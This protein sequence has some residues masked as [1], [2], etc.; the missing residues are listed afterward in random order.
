MDSTT[1]L[2][3]VVSSSFTSSN[4]SQKSFTD[5][6][7]IFLAVVATR[8]KIRTDEVLRNPMSKGLFAE[9]QLGKHMC[10]VMGRCL[11]SVCSPSYQGLIVSDRIG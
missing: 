2:N 1:G 5:K 4:N 7:A 11:A 9:H 6:D 8:Q 3:G 10:R